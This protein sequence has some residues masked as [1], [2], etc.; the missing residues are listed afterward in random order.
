MLGG[1]M[2]FQS[3]LACIWEYNENWKSMS[4]QP[5]YKAL[6]IGAIGPI[7]RISTREFNG[8]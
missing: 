1:S 8:K 6:P 5:E 3:D 4:I 2:G 7:D